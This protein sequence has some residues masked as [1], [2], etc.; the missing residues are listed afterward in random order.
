VLFVFLPSGCS[1]W[2]ICFNHKEIQEC[3]TKDTKSLK[4]VFSFRL[5][6][7]VGVFYHLS[8][9]AATAELICYLNY[10]SIKPCLVETIYSK[11]GLKKLCVKL[12]MP[13]TLFIHWTIGEQSKFIMLKI[14]YGVVKVIPQPTLFHT[15]HS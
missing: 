15:L 5:F 14:D 6:S 10:T 3:C 7:V 4:R 8:S 9:Y 13:I 1:P 11:A 2:L 12:L